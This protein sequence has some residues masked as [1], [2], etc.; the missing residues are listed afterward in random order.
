MS[1]ART[2]RTL[3]R[4]LSLGTILAVPKVSDNMVT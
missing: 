3:V 1:A 2:E 4:Q